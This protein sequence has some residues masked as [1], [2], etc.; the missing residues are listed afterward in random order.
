MEELP[1][2]DLVVEAGCWVGEAEVQ[3]EEVVNLVEEAVVEV[4]DQQLDRYSAFYL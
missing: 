3:V 4:L 2:T 1:A